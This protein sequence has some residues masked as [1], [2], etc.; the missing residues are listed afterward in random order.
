MITINT[1]KEYIKRLEEKKT[2]SRYDVNLGFKWDSDNSKALRIWLS[3]NLRSADLRYADLRY[4]DL[5]YANLRSANLR[6]ADLSY[7]NLRSANLRYADLSYADLREI[8]YAEMSFIL[9]CNL[10][11]PDI[12]L[13]LKNATQDFKNHLYVQNMAHTNPKMILDALNANIKKRKINNK[14]IISKVK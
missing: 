3:A 6:Y 5:S 7:A 4:A 12:W 10:K 14:K 1:I 8:K 9:N 13:S 2:V 11:L